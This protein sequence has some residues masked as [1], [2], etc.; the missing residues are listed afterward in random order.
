MGATS[1]G[2]GW[3]FREGQFSA[4]KTVFQRQTTGH[5][6]M[7]QSLIDPLGLPAIRMALK[8]VPPPACAA[9]GESSRVVSPLTAISLAV[10]GR[11]AAGRGDGGTHIPFRSCWHPQCGLC[12]PGHPALGQTGA[13][14]LQSAALGDCRLEAGTW[15]QDDWS[16]AGRGASCAGP[17]RD[18]RAS[19]KAGAVMGDTRAACQAESLRS[20]PAELDTAGVQSDSAAV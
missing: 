20:T 11:R 17:P 3:W 13:W 6:S 1:E 19:A 10:L 8:G 9:Q 16:W 12:P 4:G 18:L 15:A 7:R 2:W 14:P 5:T